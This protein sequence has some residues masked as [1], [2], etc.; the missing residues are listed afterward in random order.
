MDGG[1]KVISLSLSTLRTPP[2]CAQRYRASLDPTITKGEWTYSEDEKLR[3]AVAV[4][5]T[6]WS[7]EDRRLRQAVIERGI[8]DW[9][10]V[11][12]VVGTRGGQQ[13][14]RRWGILEKSPNISAPDNSNDKAPR[15]G[16][17]DSNAKDDVGP[18][19]PDPAA[20]TTTSA[21]T[22]STKRGKRQRKPPTASDSQS[23]LSLRTITFRRVPCSTL[24]TFPLCPTTM[25][26]LPT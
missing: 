5:G 14:Q 21:K 24:L 23:P 9:N 10:V 22:R 1:D 13:C 26:S 11:A 20:D 3:E 25:L 7:K 8:K 12:D 16:N 2:T 17:G 18:N 4:Y 15:D 6:H 19:T